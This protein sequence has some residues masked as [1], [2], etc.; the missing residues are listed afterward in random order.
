V[1]LADQVVSLAGPQ[2]HPGPVPH[3][4]AGDGS[5]AEPDVD[6]PAEVLVAR[7][8]GERLGQERRYQGLGEPDGG[9]LGL[10]QRAPAGEGLAQVVGAGGHDDERHRSQEQ[11]GGQRPARAGGDEQWRG[12]LSGDVTASRSSER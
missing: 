6:D 7:R 4:D 2:D 8:V 10:G 11:E 5:V 1:L 3:D 12:G 9:A